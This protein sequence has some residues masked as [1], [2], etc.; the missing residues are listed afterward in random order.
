MRAHQSSLA[1]TLLL[2]VTYDVW[3]ASAPHTVPLGIHTCGYFCSGPQC[4]SVFGIFWIFWKVNRFK[5][6]PMNTRDQK[7]MSKATC[8]LFSVFVFAFPFLF[9]HF[10][11]WECDTKCL[12]CTLLSVVS[13][14]LVLFFPGATDV[15]TPHPCVLGSRLERRQKYTCIH[16]FIQHGSGAALFRGVVDHWRTR[17]SDPGGNRKRCEVDLTGAHLT[18][19]RGRDRGVRR[20]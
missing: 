9:P 8:L 4:P 5:A 13:S 18:A 1:C 19:H 12:P 16:M 14:C 10:I 20:R 7:F 3:P 17:S 2:L 6:N 11:C 15:V